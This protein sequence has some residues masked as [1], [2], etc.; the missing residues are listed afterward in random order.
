VFLPVFIQKSVLLAIVSRAHT[1]LVM[2]KKDWQLAN[3]VDCQFARA[4]KLNA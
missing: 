3:L 1:S 4:C 2:A